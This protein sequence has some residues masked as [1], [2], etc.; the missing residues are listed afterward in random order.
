V[1]RTATTFLNIGWT[2]GNH[3]NA[4]CGHCYSWKVRKDSREFLTR[5]DVEAVVAQL[6]RLGVQTV[7]LGGNEPIYTHGADIQQSLLPFIVRTL[8]DAGIPVGLTTN[9]VSFAYLERHHPEELRLLNDID[10]SLDSPFEDEHDLN[11]G[12]RLYGLTIRAIQRAV[13]LGLDCSVIACGMRQNF[14][15]D[16]LSSYLALTKLLGCEFRVNT[17]KPL[18]PSLL[19]QMPSPDQFY[20][21]FGFLMRQTEC[22][23]LGESCLTAF[24]ET[25]TAGCPCGTSSFRINAKTREGTIPINPCVYAHEFKVGDLLRDDIFEI[26]AHPT[27]RAF[28]N[29]RHALPQACRESGCAYLEVCRGGCTSRSYFVHGDLDSKDPYCPAEYAQ[30]KGSPPEL[31]KRPSIGC[32]HGFRVHDNYLCTWIGKVHDDFS[33]PRHP[34][35]RSFEGRRGDGPVAHVSGHT[36]TIEPGQSLVQIGTRRAEERGGRDGI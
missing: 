21:G 32:A 35:I 3:C 31:P 4:S 7:N 16:Y 15:P 10:F 30:Q 11:R 18:E 1:E 8:S 33:D 23:T 12:N 34:S 2:V 22:I 19:D 24:T 25:G 13:E 20:V 28:A 17:L 5:S 14:T 29:R 26:L 6:V 27:F 36:Q 9:G